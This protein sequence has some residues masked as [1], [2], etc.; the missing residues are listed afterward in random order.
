M[1]TLQDFL[2]E[3]EHSIVNA[4]PGSIRADTHFRQM[5]GWDSLATLITLATVDGS[6]NRQI[7][8]SELAQCQ[9]FEDIYHLATGEKP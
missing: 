7:S 5:P 6:F 3:L 2:Q 9:T 8:P 4:P 1:P